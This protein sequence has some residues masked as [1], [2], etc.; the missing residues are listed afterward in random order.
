MKKVTT[1]KNR[2]G[3]SMNMSS[4]PFSGV[5]IPLLAH[6]PS[7]P[8]VI[9]PNYHTVPILSAFRLAPD[10]TSF[11]Q[12]NTSSPHPNHDPYDPTVPRRGRSYG[13][14]SFIA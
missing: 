2:S 9:Y 7:H 6:H 14:L 5:L 1:E 8:L 11:S 12:Y 4:S 10:P 13:R 3:V